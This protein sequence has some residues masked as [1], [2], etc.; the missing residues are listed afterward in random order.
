MKKLLFGLLI[1]PFAIGC[2]TQEDESEEGK[3]G[4]SSIL[5]EYDKVADE[6]CKCKQVV[7][8]DCKE[9]RNRMAKISNEA[10]KAVMDDKDAQ[11][12]MSE[13]AGK[14]GECRKQAMIKKRE[15]KE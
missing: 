13:I 5:Q 9:I 2:G 15:G 4:K 8:A 3:S 7:D 10:A 6:Y 12:E 11:Q 14:I 1:I